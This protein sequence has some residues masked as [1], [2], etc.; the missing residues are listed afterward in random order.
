MRGLLYVLIPFAA[1]S[2]IFTSEDPETFEP[3]GGSRTVEGTV[4]DFESGQALASPAPVTTSGL[5]PDPRITVQGSS[6]ELEGVPEN[7]ALQIKS[8]AESYRGT[9]SEAVIVGTE[10]VRGVMAPVVSE[11]FLASL[12][13]GF[14]VA[15]TAGRGIL[16]ARVVNDA[17]QPKA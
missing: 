10:D 11:A 4:V 8:F 6:F 14:G 15:P 9:Y 16:I 5:L 12:A 17:G 7:S 3:L 1:S 2:C 13:A